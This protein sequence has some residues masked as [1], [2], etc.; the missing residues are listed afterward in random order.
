MYLYSKGAFEDLQL[1]KENTALPVI[2]DDFIL[3]GY[4]LFRAKGSGANMVKLYA[5]ILPVKD[6]IYLMK[7]AKVLNLDVIVVVSSKKQLLEV[8]VEVEDGLDMIAVT[9]RNMRVWKVAD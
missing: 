6:I 4:Q 7:T 8:L 3:Y 9:S 2:C 5:S 1:I